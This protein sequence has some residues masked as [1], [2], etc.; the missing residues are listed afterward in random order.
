MWALL[1]VLAVPGMT[2]P[3][4]YQTDLVPPFGVPRIVSLCFW[5]GVW[6]AVFALVWRG[7]KSSFLF[8]G[9]W[10]GVAAVLVGFFIVAP[11]K[12]IPSAG[13][14]DINIWVRA[15]LIN[16]G[17]GLGVGGILANLPGAAVPSDDPALR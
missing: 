13:N 12:G 14:G 3:P 9:F 10:L 5:G 15:L 4:P 7:P 6:G 1:H 8:G 11:L 2:M 17:W 16:I